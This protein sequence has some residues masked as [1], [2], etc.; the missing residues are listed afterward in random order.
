[1]TDGYKFKLE[2]E[3]PQDD[4]NL[5]DNSKIRLITY[6][7]TAIDLRN[8]GFCIHVLAIN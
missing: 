1:M 5:D 3:M 8:T 6:D 4:E 7:D 2:Y